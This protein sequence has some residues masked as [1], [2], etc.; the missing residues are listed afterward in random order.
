[1]QA[2]IM[3]VAKSMDETPEFSWNVP[4]LLDLVDTLSLVGWR[5]TGYVFWSFN[6]NLNQSFSPFEEIGCEDTKFIMKIQVQLNRFPKAT[7]TEEKK[8]TVCKCPTV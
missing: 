7:L 6:S 2:L 1:M 3:W 5:I 8:C 4:V